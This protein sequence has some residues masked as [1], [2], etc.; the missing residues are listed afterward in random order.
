MRLWTPILRVCLITGFLSGLMVTVCTPPAQAADL[1]AR[2]R[3]TAER[4]HALRKTPEATAADWRTLSE[5]FMALHNT[6]PSSRRGADALYSAALA[7]RE[8]WRGSTE[9][10]D[11]SQ[12][13]EGFRRY[14]SLYPEDRLADDSLAHLAALNLEGFRN[15]EGARRAY[16]RMLERYPNGDQAPLARL[17]LS[18]PLEPP[19]VAASPKPVETLTAADPVR[20]APATT[21]AEPEGA[22]TLQRATGVALATTVREAPAPMSPPVTP[23]SVGMG[24]A[25]SGKA[26]ANG[27]TSGTG[28]GTLR[29]IQVWSATE[30]TRVILSTDV[31]LSYRHGKI[32]VSKNRPTRIYLDISQAHP[33][34]DVD[35][36]TPYMDKV[37]Q[38]VRVS[39]FQSAT[40]RVVLDL[41]GLDRYEI[42]AYG[43]P[44]EQKIVVD[45]F[46]KQTQVTKAKSSSGQQNVKFSP[47]EGAS[48]ASLTQPSSA[49]ASNPTPNPAQAKSAPEPMSSLRTTL[50]LKVRRIMIDPGHGGEDPG[51]IGFG[52][53]EKTITLEIAKRLREILRKAHPEIEVGMTR[54]ADVFI[55]LAE[56]PEI[57]RKFQA[58]LFVSVHLNA[59]PIERFY[60]VETYFLNLTSDQG[61]LAVAA[62]ENS[63]TEKKVS[64]LNNILFDLLRDSNIVESSKLARN[65]QSSLL[66]TL[67]DKHQ[68]IRDLG[69]KQ[70]PFLVLIGA[71]MP[72][73]LVEAGFLTN[74]KE[75][76]RLREN[77]YL[78]Q[79]AQGIYD[80]VRRYIEEYNVVNSQSPP[81]GPSV[82]NKNKSR[83]ENRDT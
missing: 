60:G 37:L 72:S 11:L 73:V 18:T 40:T 1:D 19:P 14:A 48:N 67:R 35:S 50:G 69:V 77:A 13:A 47:L 43:L 61:A 74:R 58:D 31:G 2:Y 16:L 23:V 17:K 5:A 6:A 12:A 65:L 38:R 22:S 78:Q 20:P 30:W 63:S 62:R 76:Q 42:K 25:A 56:R 28:S 44:N 81:P 34:Q 71:E 10:S 66:D 15:P 70:A 83:A 64:D 45:L 41:K 75:N 82:P 27:E 79:I 36:D 68:A 21:Q 49:K 59:N 39:R 26:S 52:V 55:P 53:Y 8:A 33:G 54:D 9:W 51:A 24:T 57:A 29:R 3:R 80:G 4:F 7:A 32:P 46:P